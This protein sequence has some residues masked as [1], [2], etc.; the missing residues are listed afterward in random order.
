M[1]GDVSHPI[2]EPSD[3]GFGRD[4]DLERARGRDRPASGDLD[5]TSEKAD[6]RPVIHYSPDPDAEAE[7][8]RGGEGGKAS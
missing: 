3:P 2:P 7:A 4:P 8:R 5:A 1:S 6:H